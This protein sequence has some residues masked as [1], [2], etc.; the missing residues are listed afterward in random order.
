MTKKLKQ[1]SRIIRTSGNVFTVTLIRKILTHDL[2]KSKTSH[3]ISHSFGQGFISSRHTA[4]C[5]FQPFLS[6][7]EYIYVWCMQ[8][9]EVNRPLQPSLYS[10][11]LET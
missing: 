1:V 8:Q 3:K 9:R 11:L 5:S 2:V 7:N 10:E 4:F 6:I